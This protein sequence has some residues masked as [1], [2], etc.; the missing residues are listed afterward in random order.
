[1]RKAL[2]PSGTGGFLYL[3]HPIPAAETY[4]SC[5]SREQVIPAG[6][7]CLLMHSFICICILSF[8]LDLCHVDR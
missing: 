6:T 2:S 1:M 5:L 8:K 3:R 7:A 4:E